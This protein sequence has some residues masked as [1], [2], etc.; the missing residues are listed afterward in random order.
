MTTVKCTNLICKTKIDNLREMNAA[1]EAEIKL[2]RERNDR[3]MHKL[4]AELG[5]LN[6]ALDETKSYFDGIETYKQE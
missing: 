4:N 1:L 5:E 2:L 3:F 6:K